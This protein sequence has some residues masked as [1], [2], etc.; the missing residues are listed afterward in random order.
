MHSLKYVIGRHWLRAHTTLLLFL[1][2][3][4]GIATYLLTR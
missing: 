3:T 1:A 4:L 2:I